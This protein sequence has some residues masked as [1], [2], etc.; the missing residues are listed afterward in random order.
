MPVPRLEI[1]FGSSPSVHYLRAVRLAQRFAGYRSTGTGR[2]IVHVVRV[3][4]PLTDDVTWDQLAQLLRLVAAWRSTRVMF[5][6]QSIG[7]WT[8]FGQLQ[9]VKACHA[10]RL[11]HGTGD[12][13]CSGKGGPSA[14]ARYFGCRCCRGVTRDPHGDSLDA[15]SWLQF[16][17][18][19]AARTSF[20]V[21][22]RAIYRA[23]KQ[24]TRSQACVFC[25]AFQWERVRGD[26]DDLPKRILLGE[27]SPFEVRFSAIDPQRA[28][29]IQAKEA[30]DV[31]GTSY[32]I[33]LSPRDDA[34]PPRKRNIPQVRYAEVAGQDAAL[35]AIQ[36]VVQLPLLHPGYFE[37]V[38]VEPQSGVILYGPPGN[39][40]TLLAKA[41]ATECAAHLEIINGPEL[42]SRWVGQAEA[43]LRQVFERARQLAPSVVLIDELDSI[44]PRRDL[45]SQPH[46]VQLLSQL[47]VLLDGLERRGRV[48][49]VATTNRL[50][51]IDPALRRSGRFDY[52][53]EVPRPDRPARRAILQMCLAKMITRPPLPIDEVVAATEGCS[54]ADLAALCREAG[55]RAI[56]RG[57]AQGT[58]AARLVVSARDLRQALATWRGQ[59]LHEP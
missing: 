19:S 56:H 2:D 14:E 3:A 4:P 39:G 20:R 41:V 37:A 51:A 29:G 18:L 44:A 27:D 45:V 23:L 25:P 10:Q 5:A 33:K 43:S 58:P 35:E 34:E 8:L 21:D 31:D 49:V 9:R 40:K 53:I 7:V 48:A 13:Y 28:L 47:L 30:P 6:G 50:E 17:R 36:N 46:E 22:K 42:L 11:R 38:G 32:E 15:P 55:L 1:T 16:G 57:L 12:A 26:V 52:H 24:R 59:R 54:G